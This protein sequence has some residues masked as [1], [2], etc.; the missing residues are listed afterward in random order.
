MGAGLCFL[1]YGLDTSEQDN[2]YLAL[3]L[4]VTILLTGTFAFFQENKSSE[5]MAGF[6]KLLPTY[7]MVIRDGQKQQKNATGQLPEHCWI[8]QELSFEP[9]AQSWCL[10]TWSSWSRATRFPPTSASCTSRTCR[11]RAPS[12]RSCASLT[13]FAHSRQLV[14][15][16]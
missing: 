4:I 8:E 3:A 13:V 7:T 16:R 6:R 15:D 12:L 11:V 5:V 9:F 2:F 1:A 14:A 10:V